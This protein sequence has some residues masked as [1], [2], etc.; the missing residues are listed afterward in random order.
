MLKQ[1]SILE[2]YSLK[3]KGMDS[4]IKN[5]DQLNFIEA[6]IINKLEIKDNQRILYKLV[7]KASKDG[8]NGNAFHQKVDNISP[9]LSIIKTNKHLIFGGFTSQ[10]WNCNTYSKYDNKAFCFQVNKKKYIIL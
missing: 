10:I 6:N 9:T 1:V 8:D 4:I 5:L 2:D 3:L 7:Y